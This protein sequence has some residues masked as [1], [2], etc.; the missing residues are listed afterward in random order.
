MYKLKETEQKWEFI[1]NAKKNF[2]FARFFFIST[3]S[4]RR[5]WIQA[6]IHMNELKSIFQGEYVNN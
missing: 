2:V 3:Q 5:L 1:R 4:N 6:H